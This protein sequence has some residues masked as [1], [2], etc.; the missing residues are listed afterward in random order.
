VDVTMSCSPKVISVGAAIAP[1]TVD[2]SCAST[3][4]DW[5]RKASTGGI[6]RLET[7]SASE[8]TYS[9]LAGTAPV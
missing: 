6:G 3:A 2:A 1:S 7:K 9:G 8:S 4:A 5:W